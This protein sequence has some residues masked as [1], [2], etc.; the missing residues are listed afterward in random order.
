MN[1]ETKSQVW[2]EEARRR[3]QRQQKQRQGK[4]VK[5]WKY[6]RHSLMT[7]NHHHDEGQE[8][9]ASVAAKIGSQNWQKEA[10]KR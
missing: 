10:E 9:T 4:R 3:R 6:E 7:I 2:R 8:G 1:E 5:I